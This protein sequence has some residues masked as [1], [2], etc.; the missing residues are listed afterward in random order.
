[1]AD[2]ETGSANSDSES[3]QTKRSAG[4]LKRL[5][6]VLALALVLITVVFATGLFWLDDRLNQPNHFADRT[7]SITQGDTLKDFTRQ[8]VQAG[9]VDEPYS[10]SL[11]ARY[12]GLAGKL[13]TGQYQFEEGLSLLAVLDAITMGKYRISHQFTFIPGSNFKQLREALAKAK[14]LSHTISDKSDL[15]LLEL[16]DD[17]KQYQHP[18]GLFFPDTYS[19]QPGE[20]DQDVLQRAYDFMQSKLTELWQKRAKNIEISSPYEALILASIIEKET[21]LASERP[22]ISGVFMNRLKKGMKLQTDPTVVYGLGD[23]YKGNITRKH[24]QT[25]TPYNTY[26]RKGLPPTPISM[27]GRAAIQAALN[28]QQTD[29]IYFVALGDGSGG[30]HF[31][32]TLAEHNKAVKRYLKAIRQR[33]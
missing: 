26:T 8:L 5:F 27:P 31:S 33:G 28:P 23:R 19:Y 10:L 14:M 1:M 21:G 2:D 18:E 4:I 15:Q 24:L 30:H 12:K 25:D 9:V 29:A 16:L 32:K 6:G 22:L 13:H 3:G 20:S 17:Q 7:F 11:A